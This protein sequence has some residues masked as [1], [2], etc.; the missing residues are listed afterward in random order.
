VLALAATLGLTTYLF[1]GLF[2]HGEITYYVPFAAA[3]LL[4]SLGSDYNVF[5]VGRI[6]SEATRQ[7]MRQ[8][9]ATAVPGASSAIS[10]ADITLAASFGLLVLVPVRAFRE[11]AFALSVGVLLD[12]FAV[13]SVLLPALLSIAGNASWWPRRPRP[14]ATRLA[15]A[16]IGEEPSERPRSAAP[17]ATSPSPRRESIS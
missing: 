13:R 11:V 12:A 8:A 15:S 6:R 7:P 1:Q 5:L 9:I 10:I 4:V 16:Q 2:G 14:R 17:Q 3:L